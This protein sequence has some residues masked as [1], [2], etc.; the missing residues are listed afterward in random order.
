MPWSGAL[1]P[2]EELPLPASAA[3][4][5]PKWE[6]AA[7]E[8]PKV[9]E[10]RSPKRGMAWPKGDGWGA[11]TG[12]GRADDEAGSRSELVAAESEKDV[13][14]SCWRMGR[15]P[16]S[17]TVMTTQISSPKVPRE[18]QRRHDAA[19]CPTVRGE[20][21]LTV[22]SVTSPGARLGTA[23]KDGPSMC[24]PRAYCSTVSEGHGAPPELRM[25]HVLSNTTP[26]GISSP[27][28]M[29]TSHTNCASGACC[30]CT[31]PAPPYSKKLEMASCRCREG[32]GGGVDQLLKHRVVV[33]AQPPNAAVAT[34]P[35]IHAPRT[36]RTNDDP[37]LRES[38]PTTHLQRPVVGLEEEPRCVRVGPSH[39]GK[40]RDKRVVIRR[41][42]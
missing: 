10:E 1:A 3:L 31:M 21:S 33:D 23:T 20:R 30:E 12:A 8:E 42:H 18:Q 19:Y 2:P 27:S 39:L 37:A 38:R 4:A 14:W 28:P 40:L 36:A 9:C 17:A 26:G 35:S 7:S 11:K 41:A 24:S 6:K 5:S 34:A 22:T 15:V 13:A 25:R 16:P 32:R 29:V